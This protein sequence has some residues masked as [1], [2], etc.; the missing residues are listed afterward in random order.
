MCTVVAR[1]I[2]ECI[3]NRGVKVHSIQSRAKDAE[4][5]GRRAAIPLE[6]DPNLPKYKNPL[7]D[8]T[9]LAVVRVITHFPGTLADVDSILNEEFDIL[10]KSN[11]GLA[12]IEEDRFGYQ[13]IHYLLQIKGDRTRL[14]EYHR[15]SGAIVEVQLRTILQHAWAEIEHDIQYKSSKTIPTEIRRR[16][17]ALAG[18]LEIADREFQAIQ[19]ADQE[20]ESHAKSMVQHG[21]LTGIKITPNSLKFFLD[22]RLGADGRISSWSYDWTT[23][24]LKDLGFHDLQQV[25]A[26]I[27]PYDD[28]RLSFLAEG[29]RQGQTKRFELM[30]LAALGD[31]FF[32]RH[33]WKYGLF[34]E[35][36]RGFLENSKRK[37]LL[38]RATWWMAPT[39]SDT[40]WI[41]TPHP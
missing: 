5:F 14:S 33:P 10:E 29:G 36:W 12:L 3:K 2:Q 7:K 8:I 30:L 24:L 37:E 23:R 1:I 6:I 19:N 40:F 31:G 38:R 28:D 35:R 20:L 25:E 15:F 39:N 26:A 17:M 34:V 32:D 18:M 22:K 13:S 11:K 27:A 21:N 41:I 16:F 4:S 9:D